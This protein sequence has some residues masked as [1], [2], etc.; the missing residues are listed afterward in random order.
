MDYIFVTGLVGSLVLVLGAAWPETKDAKR[1][2]KS[3]KNWLFATGGFIMLLYAI[4]GYQQGGP[5]FFVI[6]E[7]MV[8]VASLLMMLNTPDKVDAAIILVSGSGLVIW[9]LYLFE[10]YNTVIFI[11]GLAGVGLGYA[12]QMGT[13]RRNIALILGSVLIAIFSYM[14]ASWIFFWLNIFFAVLSAYYAYRWK[15]LA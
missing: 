10:G 9:S 12:F 13:L 7:I 11:L 15:H 1:P 4:F 8:A 3:F 6:L 2:T 5:I 14:E